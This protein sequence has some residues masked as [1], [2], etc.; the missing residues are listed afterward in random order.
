MR[1]IIS[2]DVCEQ[3]A[4]AEPF[5][6]EGSDEQF[7]VHQALGA[8][9]EKGLFTATHVA[10]GFAIARGNTIDEAIEAARAAWASKTPEQIADGLIRARAIRTARIAALQVPA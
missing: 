1:I 6:I 8:D 9:V 3:E 4:I 10:T 2:G 7:A 5:S